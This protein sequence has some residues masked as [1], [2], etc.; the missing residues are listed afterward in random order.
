MGE[1]KPRLAGDEDEDGDRQMEEM[2]LD[3]YHGDFKLRRNLGLGLG[4]E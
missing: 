1:G 2:H 4:V 3:H